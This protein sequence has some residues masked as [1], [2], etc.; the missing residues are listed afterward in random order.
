MQEGSSEQISSGSDT[1]NTDEKLGVAFS[2]GGIRSAALCS[3]VLRWLVE[4]EKEPD[5]L[6]CV[7]GGGY[8]GSAYV[9]WKYFKGGDMANGNDQPN[10]DDQANDNDQAN[11]ND[12]ANENDK[13]NWKDPSKWTDE[14][15]DHMRENT[16]YICN[17]Q[18]KGI[19]LLDSLIVLVLVLI[20]NVVLLA[21]WLLFAFPIALVINLLYGQ[22]LDGTRCRK[23]AVSIDCA[24]RTAWLFFLS[25]FLFIIAHVLEH[26]C[27]NTRSYLTSKTPKAAFKFA[28]LIS[29]S[30]FAFTFLPWFINNFLRFSGPLVESCVIFATAAFWFFVPI[31]RGY[32]SLVMLIYAYSYIVYWRVYKG[33]V[34]WQYT[35]ERFCDLMLASLVIMG[36]YSVLRELPQRWGYIYNRSRLH[37]AFYFKNKEWDISV[38]SY[39]CFPGGHCCRYCCCVCP[40]EDI[41]VTTTSS[42]GA[43]VTTTKINV[44]DRA[45][46]LGDIN[47]KNLKDGK[48]LYISSMVANNWR[49]EKERKYCLLTMSPEGIS[50]ID[51]QPVIVHQPSSA[52]QGENL[53]ESCL[54]SHQFNDK[55]SPN[56]I[57]LSSAMAMSA[58]VVSP[59]FGRHAELERQATHILTLLGFE[60]GANVVYNMKGERN[61]S[62]CGW[63]CQY[64]INLIIVTTFIVLGVVI[65]FGKLEIPSPDQACPV[66]I[67]GP[68]MLVVELL[69][70]LLACCVCKLPSWDCLERG[71]RWCSSGCKWCRVH[72]PVWRFIESMLHIIT[73]GKDPPAMMHLTDGGHF[74]NY[75]LLPLLQ[76][77]LPKI[78]LVHGLETK[79]DDD[80]A[81]DIIMAMELARDIFGCSFTSTDEN[82][83]LTDI[84]KKFVD[85]KSRTYE[86]KVHYPEIENGPRASEGR[87]LL[88][89]PRRPEED[90]RGAQMTETS[91]QAGEGT[92]ESSGHQLQQ[93][94]EGTPSHNQSWV[95]LRGSRPKLEPEKWGEGP[96]LS[97]KE[98]ASIEGCFRGVGCCECCHKCCDFTCCCFY[99]CIKFPRHPTLSQFF[100]PSIFTAYHREG[101]RVCMEKECE[102]FLG[103]VRPRQ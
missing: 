15:F 18:K 91:P 10:S 51:K 32:S 43:G 61:E 9:Q 5:Y 92:G 83:V 48:P 95:R 49:K 37:N 54:A 73:Y 76:K 20:G 62:C 17:W 36:V 59:Y 80:F 88:L 21:G 4:N 77:R 53:N 41:T 79:S 25:S 102:D 74:E 6:S 3:G 64:F 99:P 31:L 27:K 56:D 12:Q 78:I 24:Q 13:Q 29:G 33:F 26:C 97:L 69:G 57:K 38:D 100:T 39:D 75:G 16:G 93:S 1:N 60:M 52:G 67:V 50:V 35:D 30:T 90:K 84:K 23:D 87:I 42:G 63:F 55:L 19:G 82:D 85:K 34:F 47:V 28:Q 71:L 14:F 22:F 45:L 11:G 46:T 70:L 103:I 81:K 72:V 86:F 68:V 65:K 101:Y 2:G 96:Y 58:A 94:G 40:P 66:I 89:A 44:D 8:T 7:S 98:L